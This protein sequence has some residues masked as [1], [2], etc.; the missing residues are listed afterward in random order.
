MEVVATPS[1]TTLL[2]VECIMYLTI[3]ESFKTL[4]RRKAKLLK[5]QKWHACM[6]G[7][8]VDGNQGT[9]GSNRVRSVAGAVGLDGEGATTSVRFG[10]IMQDNCR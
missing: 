5:S 10:L 1:T 4:L 3:P 9:L 8:G 7:R 6:V 2:S